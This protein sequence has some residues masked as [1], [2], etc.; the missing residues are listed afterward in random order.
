M[1]DPVTAKRLAEGMKILYGRSIQI[2]E[3]LYGFTPPSNL[4]TDYSY[5]KVSLGIL[6]SELEGI[7]YY[8]NP[9]FWA[10]EERNIEE[11][12]RYRSSLINARTITDVNLP[13][14][15]S[16]LYEKILESALSIKSVSLEVKIKKV[17]EARFIP[18]IYS[19]YGF[20][21]SLKDLRVVDNPKIPYKVEDVY[22]L[23]AEEAV[24]LLYKEGFSDYY[25]SRIFSL[26]FFG[27]RLNRKLVPSK[28]SIT[29][30]QSIIERRLRQE[31]FSKAKKVDYIY[32]FNYKFYGN[33]FYGILL[34][35][36]GKVELIEAILPGSAYSIDNKLIIGRD[37]ESGGYYSLKLS[38]AEFV[39]DT[40]LLG[41]LIV[42]RIITDEYKLPLGVWVVREGIK[43]M[44]SNLLSRFSNLYEAFSFINSKLIKYNLNVFKLLRY[45]NIYAQKKITSFI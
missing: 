34:P 3:D 43:K 19:F 24:Y 40:K 42:F 28:W 41:D 45:S 27:S 30:V 17:K 4:I 21:G 35:G 37:D 26:G 12:I 25:L 13:R 8:D 11:I 39:R 16:K 10:K 33:D 1:I 7:E 36:S 22:D 14:K 31:Y 20:S 15:N 6:F 32:L 29:A 2:K 38:F 5:P 9:I 44:F 18:K 23:K